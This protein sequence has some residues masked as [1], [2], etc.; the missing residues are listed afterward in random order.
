[1]QLKITI[2]SKTNVDSLFPLFVHGL[3]PGSA[4]PTCIRGPWQSVGPRSE[5]TDHPG[6]KQVYRAGGAKTA[7]VQCN[8]AG[9]RSEPALGCTG[10]RQSEMEV[11]TKTKEK[12]Q[13]Q[14]KEKS[15]S[16]TKEKRQ[17]NSPCQSEKLKTNRLFSPETSLEFFTPPSEAEET[18]TMP[19]DM[20]Q[21]DVSTISY[22]VEN[23]NGER[24]KGALDRPAAKLLW[25][26]G[27]KLSGD[28][29]YGIAL[30]Q[31]LERSFMIDFDLKES[32]PWEVCPDKFEVELGGA[33]YSGKK[34]VQKPKP[35]ELGG[36]VEIR[37]V[38]TRFKLRPHH[39]A[40]WLEHFGR[41]IEAPEYENATDLPTV[42]SDDIVLK[43]VLRKHIPG[44]LPAYGR[45]MNIR[46]QGQPILCGKCFELGH[47]RKNCESP[48]AVK[49][50]SFVKVVGAEAFVSKEML[51]EWADLLKQSD[52]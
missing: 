20:D 44:V 6:G 33:S 25:E 45:R 9:P 13:S 15:Q 1:M 14:T 18:F 3:P 27:L 4:A 30:N 37:V 31:S 52:N 29:I 7:Y 39:V 47:I 2:S 11:N 26:K 16:Q 49:W 19:D 21:G 41:I 42:K 8:H 36:P 51:G 12:S 32:I 22:V 43:A 50:A 46:Y 24:F 35:P 28:L 40:R 5:P 10:S 34:F 17:A 38:K 23:K 48:E